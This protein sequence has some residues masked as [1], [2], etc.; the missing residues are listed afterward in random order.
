MA[1]L[2]H[3]L[4]CPSL[5]CHLRRGRGYFLTYNDKKTY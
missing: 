1:V 5:R 2:K 4:L 3:S